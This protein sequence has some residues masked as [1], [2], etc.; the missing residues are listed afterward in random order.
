MFSLISTTYSSNSIDGIFT[1]CLEP[2]EEAFPGVGVGERTRCAIA[3]SVYAED[4]SEVSR[5]GN[6]GKAW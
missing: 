4:Y 2:R 6:E 5:E 3:P 1:A